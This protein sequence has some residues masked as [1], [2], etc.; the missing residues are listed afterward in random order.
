MTL[1]AAHARV[2]T[3]TPER[4]VT[5]LC[6][7]FAHKVEVERDEGHGRIAFPFGTCTLD[8]EPDTLVMRVEGDDAEAVSRLEDVVT[9]HLHG[10]V[11]AG[12]SLAV[13]W[14]AA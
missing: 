10:F 3:P 6:K 8:A 14:T 9:R 2:A 4:Y 1:L 11:P 13:T 5:R 7:H 12:E